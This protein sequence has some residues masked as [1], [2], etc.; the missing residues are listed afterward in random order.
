MAASQLQSSWTV[1]VFLNLQIW[2][3]LLQLRC[4]DRVGSV[5]GLLINPW[6]R[7]ILLIQ[8]DRLSP[9]PAP[10]MGARCNK[11]LQRGRASRNVRFRTS[12][13]KKREKGRRNEGLCISKCVD[14]SQTELKGHVFRGCGSHLLVNSRIKKQMT[15]GYVCPV[16]RSAILLY[17]ERIRCLFFTAALRQY[18][19]FHL[20]SPKNQH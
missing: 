12:V 2:L 9:A 18:L 3:V 16:S 17:E 6:A 10:V 20:T 8:T 19:I 1:A 13:S 14:V 15:F 4:G 7:A 11:P 5:L